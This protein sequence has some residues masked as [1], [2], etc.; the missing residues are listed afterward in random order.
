MTVRSKL[1]FACFFG[2]AAC[3]GEPETT[4]DFGDT[5]DA[6]PEVSRS[7]N[8]PIP[9]GF[10]T[11]LPKV[12]ALTNA[13]RAEMGLATLQTNSALAE[14]A[15]NH[16][17][18]MAATSNFSHTGQ[19]GSEVSDR[20]ETAGYVWSFAA[21]NIAFGQPFAEGA[22]A[23]WKA[24]TGHRKNML[25]ENA[26]EIGMGIAASP[27]NGTLYWVMVLGQPFAGTAALGL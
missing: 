9:E 6:L 8:C 17:C 23:G 24:S 16:A 27:A 20:M 5:I 3:M 22:F 12:V 4:P 15:Q 21:E 1:V 10:E 7:T 25:N 13:F 26:T 19:G 2:L 11:S 14:A 18:Y